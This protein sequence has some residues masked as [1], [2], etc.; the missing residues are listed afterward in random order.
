MGPKNGIQSR[1]AVF[2]GNMSKRAESLQTSVAQQ[3]QNLS[4]IF[5]I[6]TQ[7]TRLDIQVTKAQ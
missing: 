3:N 5:Y 4:Q 2:E 6:D 1:Q 7:E